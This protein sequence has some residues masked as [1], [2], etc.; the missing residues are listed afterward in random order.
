MILTAVY[1]S[2]SAIIG[3]GIIKA[4]AYLLECSDKTLYAGWTN[5]PERRLS[6]HNSGKGSKYTRSRLPVK[7]VY[8][9]EFESQSEAMK[10]EAALKKLTRA[11]KL[12]LISAKF[13][14]LPDENT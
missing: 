5:D 10:R 1:R 6:T 9:E 7:M 12:R 13:P 2:R 3:D 8:L 11:Q 4:Y 14:L